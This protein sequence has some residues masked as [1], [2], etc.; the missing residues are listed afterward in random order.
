MIRPPATTRRVGTTTIDTPIGPLRITADDRCVRSVEMLDAEDAPTTERAPP[1]ASV[2]LRE[3]A[4]QLREYFE[5]RRA[6]FD[7]PLAIDDADEPVGTP[8]QRRVWDALRGI[9][10]GERISYRELAQRIGDPKAVRAVGL[11]NARNPLPIVVPCHR[12]IGSDGSLTGF[13]GGIE[14]KRWLLAHESGRDEP[15]HSTHP[16]AESTLFEPHR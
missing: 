12:V 7:L 5:G 2:P 11:A 14:R 16:P 15:I 9:G 6:A 1:P 8:F 4:T 3:A 10:H 13:G